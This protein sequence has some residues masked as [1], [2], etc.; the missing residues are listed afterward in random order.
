MKSTFLILSTALLL[1]FTGSSMSFAQQKSARSADF[2]RG[3][4]DAAADLKNGVYKLNVIQGDRRIIG[5]SCDFPSRDD[6]YE[7]ILK[8]KYKIDVRTVFIADVGN[9]DADID[10]ANGYNMV[11]MAAIKSRYG[12]EIFT[13]ATEQAAKE[14]ES[15]YGEKE[16]KCQQWSEEFRKNIMSLPKKQPIKQFDLRP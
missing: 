5:P 4:A 6:L 14:F 11:S 9:W 16:R 15:K 7:S 3:R 10:Y 2:E 8:E 12:T 1:L 13:Q